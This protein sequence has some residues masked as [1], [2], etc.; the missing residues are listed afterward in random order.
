MRIE[1]VNKQGVFITDFDLETNPFK[2]GEKIYIDVSNHDKEFWNI[3]EVRGH[4]K[5]E[6]IE[7]YLRKDYSPNQKY[8]SVFVTSVEVSE[9]K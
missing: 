7:H 5:I 3:N 2:I 9:I 6:K 1:I 4:Y 8:N